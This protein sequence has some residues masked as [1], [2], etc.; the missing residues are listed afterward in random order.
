MW[1][2]ALLLYEMRIAFGLASLFPLLL[3]PGYA[4]VGW[5]IWSSRNAGPPMREVLEVFSVLLP[6]SAGLAA[7]HLMSLEREEGFDEIRRTYSETSLRLPLMRSV[8]AFVGVGLSGVLA[9]S[10][11]H[12]VYD[13]NAF[14]DF[15]LPSLPAAFYLCALALLVNN[16]SGSYW[17][18]SAVVIAYWF[19]EMVSGGQYTGMLYLFNAA[20]SLPDLDPALNHI[21]LLLGMAAFLGLNVLYSVW[22]RRQS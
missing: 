18:A 19:G 16:I 7:S 21:A 11:F 5:I 14:A 12:F 4:V 9:A 22:R 6:L 17:I 13:L 1:N 2:S 8:I 15:F 3:L 20:W 10:M